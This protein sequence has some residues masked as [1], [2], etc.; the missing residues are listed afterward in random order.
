[1]YVVRIFFDDMLFFRVF[2]CCIGP[3]IHDRLNLAPVAASHINRTVLLNASSYRALS[4]ITQV[5][6]YSVQIAL[7][8]KSFL[9]DPY[10]V[11]M[12]FF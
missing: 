7:T 8:A 11:F 1:M 10:G 9:F 3:C 12:Y 2:H 4:V 6:A 5:N